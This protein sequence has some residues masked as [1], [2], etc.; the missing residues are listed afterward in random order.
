[1]YIL[2]TRPEGPFFRS[3]SVV[4]RRTYKCTQR[5]EKRKGKENGSGL[6]PPSRPHRPSVRRIMDGGIGVGEKGPLSIQST[7]IPFRLSSL[8]LLL[9]PFLNPF[10]LLPAAEAPRSSHASQPAS[11]RPSSECMHRGGGGAPYAL[12][13]PGLFTHAAE[14][15]RSGLYSAVGQSYVRQKGPEAT[16]VSFHLPR[17]GINI[18]RR[19]EVWRRD[20]L[21]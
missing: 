2:G 5:L 20:Q 10:L 12:S 1:M 15:E 21:R 6:L 4:C 17:Q 8:D 16:P 3:R 7:S 9:L 11:H 18:G 19:P 13:C 14:G